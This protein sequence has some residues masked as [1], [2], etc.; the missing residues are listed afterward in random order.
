[1]Q[2][3]D[4]VVDGFGFGRD[5]TQCNTS[6]FESSSIWISPQRSAQFKV[7]RWH[8]CG[9]ALLGQVPYLLIK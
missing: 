2:S 1:V 8:D 7:G 9:H 6:S 4:E 3:K 5:L